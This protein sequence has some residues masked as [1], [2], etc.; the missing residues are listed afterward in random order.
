M[1]VLNITDKRVT[2]E[3]DWWE[4]LAARRSHLTVPRRAVESVYVVDDAFG[5]AGE[6]RR[7]SATRL[8]GLTFTGTISA[9][10]GSRVSSFLACHRRGPGIV[11][12]LRDA[13]LDR[14]VISTPA[15]AHY[16]EQ[17]GGVAA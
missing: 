9:E 10:D 14:I 15:A 11:L 7:L 13:T 8:R 5:A 12:Q 2:V 1:A 4:K 3:L 16:A 17:L 6:G